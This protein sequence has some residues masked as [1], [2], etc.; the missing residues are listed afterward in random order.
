[1]GILQSIISEEKQPLNFKISIDFHPS[2]NIFLYKSRVRKSFVFF[3]DASITREFG[4]SGRRPWNFVA[5]ALS[6]LR[7]SSFERFYHITL[8]YIILYYIIMAYYSVCIYTYI[9]IYKYIYVYIYIYTYMHAYIHTYIHTYIYTYAYIHIYIYI[10]I[11][12]HDSL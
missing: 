11:Y 1:M 4:R 9:Y 5:P 12:L 3:T 10:Y 2:G 6:T 7:L 8:W